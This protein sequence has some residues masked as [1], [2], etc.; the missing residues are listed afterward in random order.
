MD[1]PGGG[2]VFCHCTAG[3]TPQKANLAYTEPLEAL[4]KVK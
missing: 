1:V 3:V 4:F 2:G